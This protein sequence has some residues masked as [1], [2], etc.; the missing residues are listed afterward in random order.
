MVVTAITERIKISVNPKYRGS[1]SD[2]KNT[3]FLFSYFITI[4]NQ[5]SNSVKLLKR[6][7]EIYDSNG[8]YRQIKGDGVVGLQPVI[9]PGE[10]HFYESVCPLKSEFGRMK[11]TYLMERLDTGEHFEVQ[12]PEFNMEVPYKLN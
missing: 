8:E 3:N 12:V 1:Y 4:E 5:S 10:S 6:H 9:Y 2:T 7:W 11:G